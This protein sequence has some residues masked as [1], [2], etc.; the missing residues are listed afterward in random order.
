[1]SIV[2]LFKYLQ[3]ESMCLEGVLVGEG[4]ERGKKCVW[5]KDKKRMKKWRLHSAI[6]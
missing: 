4:V 1:M 3:L 2:V 6:P 5:R